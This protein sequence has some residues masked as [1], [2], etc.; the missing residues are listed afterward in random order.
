MNGNSHPRTPV[1]VGV[2]DLAD[3]PAAGAAGLEPLELLTR[4][5]RGADQDSG[6]S[7]LHQIDSLEIINV[8]SWPY[9]D[10]ARQLSA[11]LEVRP[12]HAEHTEAGGDT[13]QRRLHEAANRIAAGRS[14]VAVICGAE[15]FKSLFNAAKQQRHPQG[16]P[17]PDPD[18]QR[19]TMHD[20]VDAE[21][22]R[23][24]FNS[25]VSVYALYENALRAARGLTDRQILTETAD[26][27]SSM[28]AAAAQS[29]AAWINRFVSP[30]EIATVGRDNR[31][32]A[33]P[34]TKL[35][36]AN[37]AVNQS[38]AILMMSLERARA[39]GVPD[40]RL[41]YVW[42]GAGAR[43]C[44]DF[45]ARDNY[46]HSPSIEATLNGALVQT[47]LTTGDLD[48]V[49]LYSCFPCVPK[50]A[51]RVLHLP[52]SLTLSVIGGLTYFGGPGNNYMTHALIGMVRK[53][54]LAGT[55][56]LLL[57]NGDLVTKHHTTVLSRQPP[58]P[59][60]PIDYNVQTETDARRGPVPERVSAYAGPATLE[61]YTVIY[62]RDAQ[63][64]FGLAICRTDR[65][66]RFAA[67]VPASDGAT[68][69]ALV[70]DAAPWIEPIGRVGT[71]RA[72]AD[73]FIEWR[74]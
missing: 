70:G 16:W 61:T 34:Y 50:L 56:G 32:I 21:L 51:R 71:A 9:R 67:R 12:R 10:L 48:Y 52:P 6:G 14:D 44:T 19:P 58:G 62:D 73:G 31:P 29:P 49:E 47:G 27:W 8:L 25:A 18:Y 59:I 60:Y 39:A 15:A 28:S 46:F 38:G 11:K 36:I 74:L 54:R 4:A 33:Y 63:P 40:H 24:G 57:G 1:I 30:D 35:M 3:R 55:H 5:V 37:D 7:F 72:G 20:V 2:H 22:M 53:L 68:L 64:S 41:V 45:M 23:Y 65:N 17:A 26:I 42:G 13:A 69:A 66:Q 43:D